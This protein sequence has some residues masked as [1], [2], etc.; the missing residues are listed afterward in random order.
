MASKPAPAGSTQLIPDQQ[1]PHIGPLQLFPGPAGDLLQI[2]AQG[3]SLGG[4]VASNAGGI[5]A[6]A[7]AYVFTALG[8]FIVNFVTTIIKAL[9][10]L[11]PAYIVGLVV[12][13]VVVFVLLG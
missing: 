13:V 11:S 8:H 9:G 5:V 3:Q 12:A 4:F 10:K 6:G 1:A 7:V 2:N